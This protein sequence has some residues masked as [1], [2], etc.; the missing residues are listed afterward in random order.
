MGSLA[1]FE[2]V[3]GQLLSV[4]YRMLGSAADAEDVV[5]EAWL[6]WDQADEPAVRDAKAWL[7]VAVVRLC[8]DKLKSVRSRRESYV[9]TW[10]PEPVVTPQPIERESISLAFLVLLEKLTPVERAVYLLHHVFEYT[11]P[12]A[13]EALGMSDAAVRQA[14]HRAKEHIAAS[15]PRFAPSPEEH[16]RLLGTFAMALATGDVAVLAQVLAR[17]ATLWADGGGK[18]RGAAV[19]AIQG[20]DK[21]VKFFEGLARSV[22]E[23]DQTFEVQEINGWPALL[24][25]SGGRVNAI[26]TIE[27]DGRQIVAV[28][29]VVNPDKLNL[30]VVN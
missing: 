23:S 28:R 12:E 30:P 17:D 1:T 19:R 18:V 25:R 8:L 3:R 14:F 22:V 9:G 15:R 13:A 6:R 27:T 11:H 21:I 24:G 10:L 7:S 20:R 29:N 4:A 26:V 5:Q 2:T 16:A